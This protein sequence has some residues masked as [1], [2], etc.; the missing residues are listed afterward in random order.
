[1]TEGFKEL[2]ALAKMEKPKTYDELQ[3]LAGR[4]QNEITGSDFECVRTRLKI[5]MF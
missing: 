5:K 2:L 3:D 1:M 4:C